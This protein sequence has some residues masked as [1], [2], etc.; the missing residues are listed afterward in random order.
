MRKDRDR[1]TE[2]TRDQK[3]PSRRAK[4]A[5]WALAVRGYRGV[6]K[7][8]L[9]TLAERA[10]DQGR[11]WPGVET[12]AYTAN[13]SVRMVQYALRTLEA[14]GLL[15]ID[16]RGYNGGRNVYQ[17]NLPALEQRAQESEVE[18]QALMARCRK[19]KR[20][21]GQQASK[22]ASQQEPSTF[23]SAEEI[24]RRQQIAAQSVP[25]FQSISA[26][27]GPN[28][29]G[30]PKSS[31]SALRK[32]TRCGKV[33]GFPVGARGAVVQPIAPRTPREKKQATASAGAR[34]PVGSVRSRAPAIACGD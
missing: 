8:V 22:P 29:E 28:V 6:T 7:C 14:D 32:S 16:Y 23:V 30:A 10:D 9:A 1:G 12:L 25:V 18:R 4:Y 15:T 26:G 11:S 27:H 3:L 21:A 33:C 13:A 19:K 2:G 20:V 5:G 31:E 34:V 24:V 17:I